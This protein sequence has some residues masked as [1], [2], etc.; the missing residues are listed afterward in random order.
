MALPELGKLQLGFVYWNASDVASAALSGQSQTPEYPKH[1]KIIVRHVES[2]TYL[3]KTLCT[4]NKLTF[5]KRL[6]KMNFLMSTLSEFYSFQQI[7]LKMSRSTVE[8]CNFRKLYVFIAVIHRLQEPEAF[9]E[10][11]TPLMKRFKLYLQLA[12]Q[13]RRWQTLR[14][15]K[16]LSSQST[17]GELCLRS[18]LWWL[19]PAPGTNTCFNAFFPPKS[20]RKMNGREK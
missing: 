20:M 11:D 12:G 2:F 18:Q 10:V 19:L 3:N 15:R 1:N 14:S 4:W 9:P 17:S 5:N 6:H 8:L 7:N 16:Q 13:R